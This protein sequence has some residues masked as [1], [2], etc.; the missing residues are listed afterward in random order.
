L[1]QPVQ[2]S[3][4]GRGAL[5]SNPLRDRPPLARYRRLLFYRFQDIPHEFA[6]FLFPFGHHSQPDDCESLCWNDPYELALGFNSCGSGTVCPNGG[7]DLRI[8]EEAHPLQPEG[9]SGPDLDNIAAGP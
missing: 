6:K 1:N 9:N 8:G 4:F 7:T 3:D 2:P 5:L